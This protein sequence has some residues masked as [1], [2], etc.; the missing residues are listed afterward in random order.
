MASASNF[1]SKT[2]RTAG[3]VAGQRR[4]SWRRNTDMHEKSHPL[5]R[6]HYLRTT[7]RYLRLVVAS[8]LQAHK[9]SHSKTFRGY[10]IQSLPEM[11]HTSMAIPKMPTPQ[12]PGTSPPN[13]T[14]GPTQSC[15]TSD[16]F[17]F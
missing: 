11:D 3:K 16:H 7:V 8:K 2:G 9:I 14:G 4:S 12:T 6:T 15:R 17:P 1:W 5:R 10:S 13:H